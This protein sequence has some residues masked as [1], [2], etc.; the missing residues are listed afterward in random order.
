MSAVVISSK[1]KPTIRQ[2]DGKDRLSYSSNDYAEAVISAVHAA[3][4]DVLKL[5][6]DG[7]LAIF[8]I[9]DAASCTLRAAR[10]LKRRCGELNAR[11]RSEGRPITMVRLGLHVGMSSTE[12][13]EAT[14]GLTSQWSAPR[15]TR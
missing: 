8:Q 13:S 14:K 1:T 15:S 7:V 4:G 6:G 9:P 2:I 3:G 10:E 11:R 12:T 5:I